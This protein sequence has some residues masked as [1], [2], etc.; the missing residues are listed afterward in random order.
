GAGYLA[1][2]NP[3]A[4]RP[5]VISRGA[6]IEDA[7]KSITSDHRPKLNL[8]FLRREVACVFPFGLEEVDVAI[9]KSGKDRRAGTVEHPCA[10]GHSK[11]SNGRDTPV[12]DQ[13]RP[14]A[15]RPGNGAWPDGTS[16]EYERF[17]R[18][19]GHR[20]QQEHHDLPDHFLSLTS[21]E[22]RRGAAASPRIG[23]D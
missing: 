11:V 10:L 9:P 23:Y 15:N 13:H 16:L 4:N 2:L 19:G 17:G 8:Q 18:D 1:I 6:D 20:A 22:D 3:A 14:I 21:R 12:F 5:C 7:S